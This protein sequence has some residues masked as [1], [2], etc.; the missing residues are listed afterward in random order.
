MNMQI[1]K[2][3][4][5][6]PTEISLFKE[7]TNRYE[8]TPIFESEVIQRIQKS[9]KITMIEFGVA[10]EQKPFGNDDE[11]FRD[12]S[13]ND[14]VRRERY[15]IFANE[16]RGRKWWWPF[17]KYKS[18]LSKAEA[19]GEIETAMVTYQELDGKS[20]TVNLMQHRK[21]I[22]FDANRLDFIDCA[23]TRDSK[24]EVLK[25]EYLNYLKERSA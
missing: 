9:N 2:T 20:T 15:A 17:E 8:I 10:I 11:T 5:H 23:Y 12:A 22:K 21:K 3:E 13:K 14:D 24:F 1:N 6:C 4:C 7:T 19:K 16:K 25:S 18:E